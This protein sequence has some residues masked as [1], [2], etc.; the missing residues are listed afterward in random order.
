[1]NYYGINFVLYE[2]STPFLNIHWFMDKLGM[3]GSRAQWIN[4]VALI[5]TF[6]ASRLLWGTYQAFRLYQDVWL[7]LRNPEELPVPPWLAF[8]YLISIMALS[9]LN[10]HW[11]VRMIQTVMSRFR[12]PPKPK[13]KQEK[14]VDDE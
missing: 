2:L 6:G 5:A 14:M 10:V 4:G 1:M 12:E 11:F 13:P 8:L 9:V 7:A 3:T